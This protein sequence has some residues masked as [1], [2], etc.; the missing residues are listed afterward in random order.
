MAKH[1]FSI[2]FWVVVTGVL[3]VVD[4]FYT[5]SLMNHAHGMMRWVGFTIGSAILIPIGILIARIVQKVRLYLFTKG[6]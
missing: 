2:L 1:R 6:L 3:A 5:P 4:V